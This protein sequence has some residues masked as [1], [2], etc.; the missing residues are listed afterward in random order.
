MKITKYEQVSDLLANDVI[1]TA[2]ERGTKTIT[3][4]GLLKGLKNSVYRGKNL[5]GRVTD[6]QWAAIKNGS[7]KDMWLGDYWKMGERI[8]RIADFNYFDIT[9]NHVVLIGE[10]F[11]F[12]IN[13]KIYIPYTNSPTGAYSTSTLRNTIKNDTN[14]APR[15]YEDFGNYKHIAN[16]VMYLS[17]AL[18]N[19]G[20]IA[21]YSSVDS[22]N[23]MAPTEAQIFGS[24]TLTFRHP[25]SVIPPSDFKQ[26]ALY[27]ARPKSVKNLYS[28]WL[29]DPIDATYAATVN[30]QGSGAIREKFNTNK[31]FSV[32]FAIVS[33]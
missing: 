12:N 2:G 15:I 8:Y 29:R 31:Y 24:Y 6:E 22:E 27:R 28:C 16:I 32:I 14:I 18:T 10:R 9:S 26:L 17:V 21:G 20:I 23:I 25:E 7:F 5:G 4:E 1:L 3:R 13:T 19:E 11:S 30:T 33:E